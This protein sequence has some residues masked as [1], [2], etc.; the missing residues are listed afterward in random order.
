MLAKF[1][2]PSPASSGSVRRCTLR[3]ILQAHPPGHNIM[4]YVRVWQKGKKRFTFKFKLMQHDCNHQVWFYICF[5]NILGISR[6]F[7]ALI[8]IQGAPDVWLAI[9]WFG[10]IDLLVGLGS[11]MKF[12]F[13]KSNS[14]IKSYAT[15]NAPIWKIYCT[16][17]G[18]FRASIG[19]LNLTNNETF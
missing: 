7:K 14:T 19:N 5:Q 2:P 11:I 15:D 3:L 1:L 18:C 12:D 6:H 13:H 17:S 4:Q 9:P 8:V 10:K 16:V